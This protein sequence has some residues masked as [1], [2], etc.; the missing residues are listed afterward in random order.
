MNSMSVITSN[1]N[2]GNVHKIRKNLSQ[3]AVISNKNDSPFFPNDGYQNENGI[4][5]DYYGASGTGSNVHSGHLTGY[6]IEENNQVQTT[7]VGMNKRLLHCSDK[8]TERLCKNY[9]F[10]SSV[11]VSNISI[12]FVAHI[13]MICV[14]FFIFILLIST[15]MIVFYC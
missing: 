2:S 5:T 4:D 8:Y 15:F 9:S 1:S 11:S 10:S 6:S 12:L 3:L 13:L 7:S 14:L